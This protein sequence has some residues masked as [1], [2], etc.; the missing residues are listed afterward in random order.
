MSALASQ[1]RLLASRHA[2]G[3]LAALLGDAGPGEAAT[4]SGDLELVCLLGEALLRTGRAREAR[5]R[6]TETLPQFRDFGGNPTMRRAR[7][8]C[9]AAHFELGDLEAAHAA[10]SR[11]AELAQLDG[12]HLLVAQSSNNLAMIANIRGQH[13]EALALYRVALV[14]Y[15]RVGEAVGY[16]R[17]LHNIAITYRDTDRFDEADEFEQRAIDHARQAKDASL[18]AVLMAARADVQL[19]RGDAP[20]A[21]A[22]ALHAAALLGQ[23]PDPAR[24]ADALRVAGIARARK[25]DH[26][27][28]LQW[29]DEAVEMAQGCG[30]ALIEAESR[31]ARAESRL[32]VSDRDGA[33]EDGGAALA[34]FRKLGAAREEA[35]TSRWL[36]EVG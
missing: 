25:G 4:V 30:A 2:W 20:M 32:A 3:E 15:Q 31:R 23:V 33:R 11:A 19:L 29:F 5:A 16:A 14:A 24:R 18:V 17:S 26:V 10:F 9:G 35:T 28:A 8:L 13:E 6:F 34:I 27:R 22:T 12:D 21:E 7:N 36:D 1:A